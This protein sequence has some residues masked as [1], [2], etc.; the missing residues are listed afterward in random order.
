MTDHK[1]EYL[2]AYTP[3][4]TE[5]Y[6]PDRRVE[7]HPGL[8]LMPSRGFSA[9]LVAFDLHD[10]PVGFILVSDLGDADVKA[11]MER[12]GYKAT[13]DLTDTFFYLHEHGEHFSVSMISGSCIYATFSNF[14]DRRLTDEQVAALHRHHEST[15]GNR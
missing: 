7:D 10:K 13:I 2:V 6:V 11:W 8:V 14:R 15:K 3:G 12:T 4:G 5:I 9:S 1:I